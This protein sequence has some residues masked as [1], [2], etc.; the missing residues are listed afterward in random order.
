VRIIS[1]STVAV[2]L[3]DSVHQ[4]V[5]KFT[6]TSHQ[7]CCLNHRTSTGNP[8]IKRIGKADSRL[9]VNNVTSRTWLN[10][11]VEIDVFFMFVSDMNTISDNDKQL[12][13]VR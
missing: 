3:T 2:I 8:P 5:A 4:T 1:L 7:N 13:L 12:P 6:G 9:E 11:S 10:R